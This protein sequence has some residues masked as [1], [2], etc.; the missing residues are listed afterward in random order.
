MTHDLRIWLER[1]TDE[2]VDWTPERFEYAFGLPDME[3][4]D[5]HSSPEPALIDGRYK[6]RGSIDMIERRGMPGHSAH[7]FHGEGLLALRELRRHFLL[8]LT[9]I[10]RTRRAAFPEVAGDDLVGGA[11]EVGDVDANGLGL[12]NAVEAADA[13]LDESRVEG[14]VEEDEV[15]GEL[16]VASLA[17][18]LGAEEQPRALRFGE[19]GRLPVALALG[20]AFVRRGNLWAPIGLH[21]T[22]NAV[23]LILAEVGASAA[24]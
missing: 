12:A 4:R 2:G 24:S 3:G 14:E 16:E 5:P 15:M 18:D 22:F 7:Q 13:L 11:G 21:A 20:W 9:L 6:L 10:T 17:A 19:P 23:L 1:L 8:V